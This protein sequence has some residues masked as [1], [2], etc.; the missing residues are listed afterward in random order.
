MV[1]SMMKKWN[2]LEWL[3]V[4]LIFIMFISGTWVALQRIN[5]ATA[6]P[7]QYPIVAICR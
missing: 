4:C 7:P 5:S 3:V 2:S 6:V 1:I